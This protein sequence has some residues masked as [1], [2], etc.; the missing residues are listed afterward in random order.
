MAY[1]PGITT[2]TSIAIGGGGAIVI[3]AETP[4]LNVASAVRHAL[5]AGQHKSLDSWPAE[6]TVGGSIPW[7]ISDGDATILN[8]I[9]PT[10]S[11]LAMA[12]M[13]IIMGTHKYT[14]CKAKSLRIDATFGENLKG[15]LGF[16]GSAITT[17]T[18]P[19]AATTNAFKCTKL[20]VSGLGTWEPVSWS[21]NV[22]LPIKP[23][24]AM[25]STGARTPVVLTEGH[26][27]ITLNCK[28]TQEETVPADITAIALAQI[29]TVTLAVEDTEGS[30]QSLTITL[31][32]VTPAATNRD[33]S[34]EDLLFHGLDY[35]AE[36]YVAAIA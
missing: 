18:N 14:G 30:P 15:N 6:V 3:A 10:G 5:A 1:V 31:T 16:E 24:H 28:L 19:G 35:E 26:Q 13:D 23:V 11:P 20:T 2:G 22:D 12:T 32:N 33:L 36:T 34:P 17:D 25:T 27:K 8:V 21:V 7:I 29:A 9:N 4:N